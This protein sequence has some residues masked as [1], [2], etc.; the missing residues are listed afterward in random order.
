MDLRQLEYVIAVAEHGGF[1]RAAGALGVAQPSLSQ[2]VRSLE[3]EL[4]VELFHRVGRGAVPSAAG[5]AFLGP[6]RQTLRDAGAARAAVSDVAGVLS[7]RLDLVCLPSLAARPAAELVGRFRRSHPGVTVSLV[8][9]IDADDVTARLRSGRSE[10]GLAEL[11]AAQGLEVVP[12]DAHDYVAVVPV[13]P[14][15]ELPAGDGPLTLATLAG[16]PMV[17]TPPGTSTRRQVDDAFAAQGLAADVVVETD[18]R[19]AIVPLVAAGAGVALLPRSLALEDVPGTRVREVRPRIRRRVGL[20]HRRGLLSPAARA[21]V[22][23]AA[24]EHRAPRS[25]PPARRRGR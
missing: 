25:R 24:P 1:T 9:P 14:S 3:S 16:L 8:E 19:E 15:I 12:L 23:L 13:G 17:T 22:A 4:G 11:P 18:H 10:I 2:G 5:T 7:G 21:F 6:A 20:V